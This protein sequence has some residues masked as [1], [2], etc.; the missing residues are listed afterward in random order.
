MPQPPHSIQPSL[1]QVRH[2]A[3]GLPTEAPRQTKQRRSSSADGSVNGKYDGRSRV[4]RP[5]PNIAWAKWSRVPLRWAIV[6]PSS[7]ARPSTWWNTG[8]WVASSSSVRNVRPGHT[9]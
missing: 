5:S 3:A 8:V 6:R 1:E 7:T 9:T 4:V 2:G